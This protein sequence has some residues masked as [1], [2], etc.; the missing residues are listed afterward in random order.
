MVDVRLAREQTESVTVNGVDVTGGHGAPGKAGGDVA[1]DFVC[2]TSSLEEAFGALGVR[3]VIDL[4]RPREVELD[5]RVPDYPGLAYAH[6]HLEHREWG[7]QPY[8]PG[9]E[10]ARYLAD[11]Y[12]DLCETATAGLSRA[13]GLIADAANAPVVVHCA[14]GKDRTG[15]VCG[16][17]LAALGVSDDDI[18]ADYALSATTDERFAAW[19][20]T[21][22]PAGQELP[23]PLPAPAEA[24]RY[25]LAEVRR[26]HGSVEAYLRHTGVRQSQLD[27]LRAHLLV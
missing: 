15:I 21:V 23:A 7:E 4:R 13:V 18:A 14:V 3:T 2:T 24:M 26:E 6:I 1:I 12:R 20:R 22:T 11:R 25:F 19:A 16:L 27:A 9:T 17:T 10:L 8:R 5:G